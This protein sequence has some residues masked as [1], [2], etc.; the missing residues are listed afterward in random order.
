M[1][2]EETE[3]GDGHGPPVPAPFLPLGTIRP[4]EPEPP[5]GRN[6]PVLTRPLADRAVLRT[7]RGPSRLKDSSLRLS[8]NAL[9]SGFL[10]EGWGTLAPLDLNVLL[11]KLSCLPL[12]SAMRTRS[13]SPAA[14]P[15]LLP[16]PRP[17]RRLS[18]CQAGIADPDRRGGSYQTQG[19]PR[20][21]FLLFEGKRFL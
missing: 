2:P 19:A 12:A 6:G 17:A 9:A 13:R 3:V 10:G 21:H 1:A 18:R 5:L 7:C 11:R 8:P 4:A 15:G 20:L 14:R 16:A